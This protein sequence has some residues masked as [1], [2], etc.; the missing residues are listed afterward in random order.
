M[1]F[2]TNKQTEN[3]YKSVG[4]GVGVPIAVLVNENSASASELL[5]GALRDNLKAPIIGKNT[6]GKGVVQGTYPLCDSS[7]VKLTTE[8][9]FTP[10]GYDI[11][12][13]G[14]EPDYDVELKSTEDEQLQLAIEVLKTKLE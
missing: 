7:V 8:K 4:K 3:R 14:L 10:N 13:K 6:F 12:E 2:Y 5:A 1:I 9:Y 11:N